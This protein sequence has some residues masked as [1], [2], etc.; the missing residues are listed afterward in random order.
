MDDP[1]ITMEDYIMFEEGKAQKYRKVFNWETVKYG[2]IWYD[3]DF[4]DLRSVETEFPTIVFNDNFTLDETISCEPTT[5]LKIFE[6]EFPAIV[7]NN[8]LT[9]K[10]DFL[11]KPAVRLQH[12]DEFNLKEK[13]SL[14]ECDENE[15][16]VLYFDDRF[17]LK[18]IY[19]DDLK[20][21]KDNDDDEINIKP[22]SRDMFVYH[23]LM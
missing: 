22:Y 3:E 1:S 7:Y 18:V 10:L 13:T 23:Y 5:S 15:K 17:P 21:D 11:T 20:S 8:A 6:N 12:I 14:F 16:T 19:P 2:K 4:Y 9:S